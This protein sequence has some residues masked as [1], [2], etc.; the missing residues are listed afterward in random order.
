MKEEKFYCK[1]TGRE[2]PKLTI[3]KDIIEKIYGKGAEF[4]E[5]AKNDPKRRRKGVC[6]GESEKKEELQIIKHKI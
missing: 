5:L 3:P 2:V 1:D 6:Y 4:A